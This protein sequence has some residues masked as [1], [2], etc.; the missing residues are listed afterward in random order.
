M[1][2][3]IKNQFGNTYNE[4]ITE[5]Y[6]HEWNCYNIPIHVSYA[7]LTHELS[8]DKKDYFETLLRVWHRAPKCFMF[9][10]FFTTLFFT[11]S[12]IIPTILGGVGYFVGSILYPNS[13]P[14]IIDYTLLVFDTI[15]SFLYGI[16]PMIAV[17]IVA[18]TTERYLVIVM[19]LI[20]LSICTWIL[21]SLLYAD[22]KKHCAK[23][24]EL[25]YTPDDINAL[26][27]AH[28]MVKIYKGLGLDTYNTFLQCW[29]YDKKEGV[30]EED[31][32]WAEFFKSDR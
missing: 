8:N 26:Y 23:T 3:Q 24:F 4:S 19:Y 5:F 21:R 9:I 31:S 7:F 17:T 14:N 30:S 29:I 12:L 16:I 27:L 2:N 32:L 11:D 18:V 22:S 1:D 13:Y 6:S 28:R 20:V 10:T 15:D 25:P